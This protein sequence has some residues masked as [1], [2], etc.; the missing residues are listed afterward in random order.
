MLLRL[1]KYVDFRNLASVPRSEDVHHRTKFP[2]G[3]CGRPNVLAMS[4][5]G[6]M[7]SAHSEDIEEQ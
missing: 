1:F 7:Q 3:F 6:G 5:S 2:S 4:F